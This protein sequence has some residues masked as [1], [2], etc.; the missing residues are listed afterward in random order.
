MR[1]ENGRVLLVL[2][3]QG[4]W[5]LNRMIGTPLPID[6]FLRLAIPL[7]V[8]L[9]QAHARGLIH[10]D[11]KPANILVDKAGGVRLTGFGIAIRL[12]HERQVPAP[13]ERSLIWRRNRRGG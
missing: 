12:P 8:S 6:A 7:T 10:K 11:L 3:D 1:Y 9:G 5:T 2:E 13:P 4:G